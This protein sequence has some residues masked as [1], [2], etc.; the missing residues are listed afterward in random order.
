ML[1]C[2]YT[3]QNA[4]PNTIIIEGIKKEI[5]GAIDS[6]KCS[7]TLTELI[8]NGFTEIAFAI[9]DDSLN[10]DSSVNTKL[11][12]AKLC[13]DNGNFEKSIDYIKNVH[14]KALIF[15][16]LDIKVAFALNKMDSLASRV[17]LDSMAN[18]LHYAYT[19]ER[20]IEY[21]IQ[22][23]Y[24]LHNSKRF[25]SAITTLK[26]AIDTFSLHHLD[27]VYLA[28]IYR[29]LGNSYNDLTRN[30]I[31]PNKAKAPLFINCVSY[32]RKEREIIGRRHE[33]NKDIGN[34]IANGMVL[35]NVSIDSYR[36]FHLQALNNII[37]AIDTDYLVTRDP[38]YASVCFNHLCPEI[39]HF[40]TPEKILADSLIDLNQ[41]LLMQKA[42][43]SLCSAKGQ[44]IKL[45]F[46][47][48][49]YKYKFGNAQKDTSN[50][51]SA[52]DLANISNLTKY[53]DLQAFRQLRMIYGTNAPI[54]IK[55]W[56]LL[57][58]I[59]LLGIYTH[60]EYCR[61]IAEQQLSKYK[62]FFSPIHNCVHPFKITQS[63]INKLVSYCKQN[64]T[65]IYDYQIIYETD[66]A[67]LI[68]LKFD[69]SG[70][71]TYQSVLAKDFPANWL[72]I[73]NKYVLTDSIQPYCK[74][75]VKLYFT[76]NLNTASTTNIIISPCEQL[77]QFPIDALVTDATDHYKWQQ[78]H[79][80]FDRYNT[81][82][83]AN[84]E[85]LLSETPFSSD[86]KTINILFSKEDNSTLSSNQT[87]IDDLTRK[88]SAVSN[89]TDDYSILHIM[90]HTQTDVDGNLYFGIPSNTVSIFSGNYHP[91]L[92]VLHGCRSGNGNFI[93][94]EGYL[95]LTR[96]FLYGGTNS[97][98][99]S[100][101]NADNASSVGLFE[102]FYNNMVSGT[103]LTKSLHNAQMTV[104]NS[105][106][107][108]EWAS[109]Y[110]WANWKLTGQDLTFPN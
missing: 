97:V 64:A 54:V 85:N 73:L 101:W 55:Y 57:H 52:V 26:S 48:G 104:K 62:V 95:S 103:S 43:L 47:Q 89:R 14:S 106:V 12:F 79:F 22:K 72:T 42:I 60:N 50:H 21:L 30:T 98:I 63:D 109:P 27:S 90:D 5:T 91:H 71:Y 32:Y 65:T 37:T 24:H 23:G 10:H 9:M 31:E 93:S 11:W 34:L 51:I 88:Y 96:M 17:L 107:Y 44:D 45:C 86:K 68:T 33:P 40:D 41:R 2:S 69:S 36:S 74:L 87:L 13:A 6:V 67:H 56:A 82:Y 46:P 39:K 81:R 108:A 76:L 4:D 66:L 110:Y 84:L 38:V 83:V 77:E 105:P 70:L 3:K 25:D 29:K 102:I 1:S 58:E 92:A 8:S 78:A 75:A 18:E 100:C 20:E 15:E 7:Q 59:R 94:T 19:P 28:R 49:N 16:L 53:S 61:T 80:F 99:N 35:I